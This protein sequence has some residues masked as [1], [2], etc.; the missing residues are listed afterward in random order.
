MVFFAFVS[1]VCATFLNY[2]FAKRWNLD[3]GIP[4]L[5]FLFFTDVVFNVIIMVLIVLPIMALFAK[6]TPK[7]IEGTI[8]AFLTGTMNLGYGVISPAMGTW[9][10]YQF[11]GV[12][13]ND[14]SGY[15]TLCLIAFICSLFN[16]FLLFLIPTKAQLKE[17]KE[18][19]K[20]EEEERAI[21]R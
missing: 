1:L 21:E 16:F 9:I 13:K 4:D 5:V 2:F 14:L 19:R 7:K 11:V 18:E 12:N 6:I 8:F 10:N 3:C 17:W 20:K 15:S